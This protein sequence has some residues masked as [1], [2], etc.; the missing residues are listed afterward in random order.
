MEFSKIVVFSMV[1]LTHVIAGIVCLVSSRVS[2]H[3]LWL[4]V[5][6]LVV[7]VTNGLMWLLLMQPRFIERLIPHRETGYTLGGMLGLVQLGCY[8]AI[9]FGLHRL[10]VD[11]RRSTPRRLPFDGRDIAGEDGPRPWQPRQEGRHDIQS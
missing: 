6:F 11:L 3:G 10:F 8:V 1:P 5:S 4:G 9:A 7:A 2:A